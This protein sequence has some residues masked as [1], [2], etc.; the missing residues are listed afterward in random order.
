MFCSTIIESFE[1]YT[2][3][4]WEYL[5]IQRPYS[6]IYYAI[7]GEAYYQIDNKKEQFKKGHL[8]LFPANTTFSLFENPSNKFTTYTFT[9]LF[10]RPFKIS[11]NSMQRKTNFYPQSYLPRESL[12]IKIGRAH[13]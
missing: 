4:N 2:H 13:V 1:C 8:Y 12:S 11:L 7:D 5:N 3:D 9:L 10:T 6:I